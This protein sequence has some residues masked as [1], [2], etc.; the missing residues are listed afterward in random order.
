MVAMMHTTPGQ[1][2]PEVPVTLP[3]GPEIQPAW[4]PEPEVP[5]LPPDTFDPG[6]PTGPEVVPDTTPAEVP[7]PGEA[8]QDFPGAFSG[9]SK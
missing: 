6:A 2:P 4:Q 1:N 5:S 8:R 3:S 7:D 9:R